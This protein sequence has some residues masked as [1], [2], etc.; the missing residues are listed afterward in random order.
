MGFGV[1]EPVN[2]RIETRTLYNWLTATAG[3]QIYPNLP[4]LQNI[5]LA[6]IKPKDSSHSFTEQTTFNLKYD[7]RRLFAGDQ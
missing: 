3:P 4:A 1:F 5:F 2:G 6:Q 7:L